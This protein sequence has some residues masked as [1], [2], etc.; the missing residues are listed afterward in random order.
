M[1]TGNIQ[2]MLALA[3]RLEEILTDELAG[4][5]IDREEALRVIADLAAL[6]PNISQSLDR[7]A[8]RMKAPRLASVA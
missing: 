2:T 5:P 8:E 7:I 1:N 6:C 4:G 3:T